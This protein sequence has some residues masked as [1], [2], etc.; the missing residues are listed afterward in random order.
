MLSRCAAAAGRR[1]GSSTTAKEACRYRRGT[2]QAVSST[3]PRDLVNM[4]ILCFSSTHKTIKYKSFGEK[5]SLTDLLDSF[6]ENDNCLMKI[7]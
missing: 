4:L 5:Y 2:E 1:A 3:L 7:H 6:D